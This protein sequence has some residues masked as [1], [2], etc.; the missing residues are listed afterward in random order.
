MVVLFAFLKAMLLSTYVAESNFAIIQDSD[1]IQAWLN[2]QAFAFT[3]RFVE[4]GT[5]IRW[6][7]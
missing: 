2:S 1:V 3:E 5:R 6:W 4:T 7:A